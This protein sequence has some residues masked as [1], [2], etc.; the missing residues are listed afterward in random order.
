M[1][2]DLLDRT[3]EGTL[4]LDYCVDTLREK[5]DDTLYFIIDD[6]DHA[7]DESLKILL[8]AMYALRKRHIKL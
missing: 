5:G 1:V 7:D 2:G 4:L 3:S 6:V 8:S